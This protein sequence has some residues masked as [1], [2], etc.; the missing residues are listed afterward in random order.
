MLSLCYERGTRILLIVEAPTIQ[1]GLGSGGVVPQG[2][3]GGFFCNMSLADGWQDTLNPK[4]A[5]DIGCSDYLIWQILSGPNLDDTATFV[6]P[7]EPIQRGVGLYDPHALY[8][9][10]TYINAH[11]ETQM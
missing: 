9:L 8:S 2:F 6:Y 5:L 4:P 11:R 10:Y 7:N 3:V 1:Y